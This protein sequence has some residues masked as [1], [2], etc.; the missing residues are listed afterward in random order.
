M[1][2]LLCCLLYIQ[3]F[4][5]IIDKKGAI[6]S[7]ILNEPQK[8][9]YEVIKG[10]WAAGR[11]VRIIILK[12]R[13]MGFSTLTAAIIFWM[14]ATAHA[15][16]CMVVAHKD[17]ATDNLFQM[18]K[19]F[20]ENLPPQIQP[21]LQASNAKELVFDAPSRHAGSNK[22]LGSRIRCATAGGQGVG[23]SY[24]LKALHLSEVSFWPGDKKATLTGL[25]QAVPDL[26]GTLIVMESTP[27]GFEEFKNRWDAAV[28]AQKEGRE[29]YIPIFFAW[30]EMKEY[31]RKVP[32]GFQR[33]AE[34][35]EL[36]DTY[37]LDDQQLAWQRWAIEN[38]CGG[39]LELFHQEYPASPEEAF[40]STGRCAF[41][42]AAIILRLEKVRK[43]VWERGM[44]RIQKDVAGKIVSY[45]WEADPQGPIRIR[46]KPEVGVPYVFGGDTAGTGSDFFAGHMIDNR[47]GHQ[48]AV[49]HHQFGER[50]F[51]E[52]VYCLGMW[53]NR[54][55]VG[56]EV[57]Y[58]TYPEMLLE[59]LGYP[60]LYVRERYD[61]FTGK[62]VNAFGFETNATTRPVIVDGL[63]DVAKQN[64]ECIHDA[65]TLKEMLT[66][67]YDD[68]WKAQAENGEHDDLVMSLG[69]THAIRSQQ[70]TTVTEAAA[71][72][73][74]WT[75]DMW[76][77][78]RKATPQEREMMITAWGRPS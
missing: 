50:T 20:Y 16:R 11:P 46:Q 76:E 59:E 26:P 42:K 6:V 77:D 73:R 57:N 54:A 2:I 67:V 70:T 69:I 22:G 51:A 71:A 49:V 47:T 37:H 45:Q 32:K 21:M 58:S 43:T 48:V 44:F 72:G 30:F 68:K 75:A 40:I 52:Q 36:V 14:A 3:R 28:D 8:R 25:L 64:L 41:N 18:Y 13:Q 53:Y 15:V 31:R 27:N 60:K 10:E 78:Y 35:Q 12:A 34:E 19:R 56:I 65:D 39:D 4:L 17:E 33:T 24:T 63:K 23:R 1:N 66:F 38:L 62:M 5:K 9:L 7:L 55:L 74:K 61:D 29:G